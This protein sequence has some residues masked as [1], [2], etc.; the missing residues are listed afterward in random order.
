M[1]QNKIIAE[2]ILKYYATNLGRLALHVQKVTK[3]KPLTRS[4]ILGI[5]ARYC[6]KGF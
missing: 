1:A 3:R 2:S 4:E 6:I 5:R